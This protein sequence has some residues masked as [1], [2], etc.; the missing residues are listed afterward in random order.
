MTLSK[1][2][3]R[4]L[5]NE[6]SGQAA[7]EIREAGPAEAPRARPRSKSW[8]GRHPINIRVTIPL[9]GFGTYYLTLLAGKERRGGERLKQER[10]KHPLLTH[11]NMIFLFIVGFMVGGA[12]WILL[13]ALALWILGSNDA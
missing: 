1:T 12:A 9:F 7:A 2:A 6:G 13:R 4:P 8:S 3:T 11:A 10:E 5:P